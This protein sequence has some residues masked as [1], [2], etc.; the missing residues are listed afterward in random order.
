M[1]VKQLMSAPATTVGP[2]DSLHIAAERRP[3]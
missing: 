1:R 2:G 3:C